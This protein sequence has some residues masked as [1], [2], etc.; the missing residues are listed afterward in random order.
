MDL[1][2]PLFRMNKRRIKKLLSEL[3]IEIEKADNSLSTKQKND[4]ITNT[5]SILEKLNSS[6]SQ[7]NSLLSS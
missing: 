3:N 5:K 2:F 6:V 4:V 1:L 7:L